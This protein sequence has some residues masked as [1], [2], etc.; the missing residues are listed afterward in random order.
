MTRKP[1][2]PKTVSY[3]HLDVYKRQQHRRDR[4]RVL[5]QPYGEKEIRNYERRYRQTEQHPKQGG[6]GTAETQPLRAEVY[7]SVPVRP[8]LGWAANGSL[9]PLRL[10][11]TA[12]GSLSPLRLG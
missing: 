4:R 2:P 5:R 9:S 7:G 10:G 3:T 11:W 6:G 1:K 8:G 12:D